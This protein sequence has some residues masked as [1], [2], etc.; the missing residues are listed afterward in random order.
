MSLKTILYTIPKK[1]YYICFLILAQTT[2][3]DKP[4]INR[5]EKTE[6]QNVIS[7]K[8]ENM[9]IAIIPNKYFV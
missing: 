6:T 5:I 2:L 8:L 3:K 1:I 7:Y 4:T 9:Y